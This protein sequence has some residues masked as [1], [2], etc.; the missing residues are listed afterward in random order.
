MPA[1]RDKNQRFTFVYK[2][3]YQIYRQEKEQK[4]QLTPS[5]VRQGVQSQI[6]KVGDLTSG[7]VDVKSFEPA[8]FIQPKKEAPA[9]QPKKRPAV[10]ETV[11]S[12]RGNLKKLDDLHNRLQFMLQE[13]DDLVKN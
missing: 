6:I 8:A 11:N 7:K 9:A 1:S 5:Q 4:K 3:L 2:N 12:L 13:L 10:D